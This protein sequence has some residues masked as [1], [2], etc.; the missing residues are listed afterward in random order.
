MFGLAASLIFILITS[1]ISCPFGVGACAFS[2][3]GMPFI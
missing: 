3:A 1:F 2:D